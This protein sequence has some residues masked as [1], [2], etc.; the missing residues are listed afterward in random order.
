MEAASPSN[1]S[2]RTA[3]RAAAEPGSYAVEDDGRSE[4][5][6]KEL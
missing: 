4:A 3:L 1:A 2:Q 6:L 5:Q